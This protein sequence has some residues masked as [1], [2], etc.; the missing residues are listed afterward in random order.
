VFSTPTQIAGQT[1]SVINQFS[2]THILPAAQYAHEFEVLVNMQ[3]TRSLN[4]S[5]PPPAELYS[6]IR[7]KQ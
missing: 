7:R 3:V 1:A 6:E 2:E 5:I 4:L